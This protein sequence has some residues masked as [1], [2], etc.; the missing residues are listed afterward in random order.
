MKGKVV[1]RYKVRHVPSGSFHPGGSDTPDGTYRTV[2]GA[3]QAITYLCS[4]RRHSR[5]DYVV[6]PFLLAEIPDGELPG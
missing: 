4:R 5:E 2:G 3:R 6:V 1:V